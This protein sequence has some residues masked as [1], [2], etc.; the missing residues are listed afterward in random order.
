M[1]IFYKKENETMTQG[2]TDVFTTVNVPKP[3]YED[4]VRDSEQLAIVKNLLGSGRYVSTDDLKIILGLKE[5]IDKPTMS[6][7]EM[8]EEKEGEE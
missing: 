5:V 2:I 8:L 7:K 3:E 6:L 1:Q 4:L